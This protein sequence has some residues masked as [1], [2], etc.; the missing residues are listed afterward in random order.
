MPDSVLN[1]WMAAFPGSAQ[2]PF[3]LELAGE[4]IDAGLYTIAALYDRLDPARPETWDRTYDHA[5]YKWFLGPDDR[6][7]PLALE[8]AI[9]ARIHDAGIAFAIDRYLQAQDS[10]V[11][12][13]MGGHNT[14]RNDGSFRQVAVM[15]RALRRKGLQVVTGGGPGL[16]EA[17]NFGAFA[18]PF[19]DD[20]FDRALEILRA[21]EFADGKAPWLGAACRARASLL[22]G[23]WAAVPPAQSRNLGIPTWHYGNEPPNVFATAIGKYFFNS[24]RED[25]LISVASGGLVFGTGAA[26]TVQEIFQN[27]TLNY[28]RP[29]GTR[30]TPMVFLGAAMWNAPPALP[31]A[32]ARKWSGLP[33]Y[34]LVK[35]VANDGDFAE[36]VQLSDDPEAIVRFIEEADTAQPTVAER[37]LETR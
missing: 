11:V 34:A 21:T 8:E 31:G 30:P 29:K 28:Y 37:R 20:A 2:L 7:R 5:N 1:A 9:A 22:G 33:A 4:G 17:A 32:P 23:D 19:G 18:A 13:F 35:A 15:A 16:M 3:R 36:A 14:A 6:P 24:V 25:G 26:G 10:K 27:A 12:G